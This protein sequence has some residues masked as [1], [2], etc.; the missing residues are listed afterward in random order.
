MGGAQAQHY[1]W[2][3]WSMGLRLEGGSDER[4]ESAIR[5]RKIVRTWMFRGTLHFVAASDLFW[6]TKLLSPGI[7]HRNTRRYKQLELDEATFTKSEQVLREVLKNEGGLTRSE[8]KKYFE[9]AGINA[10]GQR[11]PYLLQHAS[12]AEI[13]CMGIPRDREPTYV[14]TSKWIGEQPSTHS[15][16]GVKLLAERYLTS[17]GPATLEDFAWWSGLSMAELRSAAQ[18]V[19]SLTSIEAGKQSYWLRAKQG[20]NAIE[21]R[22]HL[23]PPFDSYLLGYKER[24]LALDPKY[25]KDVN[26]GGGIPK[27][28]AIVNGNVVGTWKRTITKGELLVSV[29]AFRNLETSERDLLED[30]AK[31]FGSFHAIPMKLTM[32]ND[33]RD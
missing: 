30:A 13:I 33:G 32:R 7:L 12:L 18:N 25:A 9:D 2:A 3:K 24:S 21:G 11:M 14:L 19:E 15:E 20:H 1:D 23:L 29:Q 10:E 16:K 5:Q 27:P 4:V 26:P 6:L 28:T 8:I 17:H 31:R 22:G